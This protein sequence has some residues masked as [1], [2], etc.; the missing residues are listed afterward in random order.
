M[1]LGMALLGVTLSKWSAYSIISVR[2]TNTFY[3]VHPQWTHKEFEAQGISRIC[4]NSLDRR[5]DRSEQRY[6][7][8]QPLVRISTHVIKAETQQKFSQVK[9]RSSKRGALSPRTVVT[10]SGAPSPYSEMRLRMDSDLRRAWALTQEGWRQCDPAIARQMEMTYCGRCSPP[11][12]RGFSLLRI[13]EEEYLGGSAS[14]SQ[15]L[16][17]SHVLSTALRPSITTAVVRRAPVCAV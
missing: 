6:A 2:I 8:R 12:G 10:H 3:S 5:T 13:R 17:F 15:N 7:M 1:L 14:S 9:V 11:S 4:I 16:W